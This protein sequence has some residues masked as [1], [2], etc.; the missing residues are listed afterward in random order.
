[1][2]LVGGGRRGERQSRF[3]ALIV[4]CVGGGKGR[5]RGREEEGVRVVVVCVFVKGRYR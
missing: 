2:G 4:W 3:G 1:M 5:G